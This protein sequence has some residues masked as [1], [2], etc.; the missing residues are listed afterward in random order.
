MQIPKLI[1]F[2]AQPPTALK[3][4]L[5]AIPFLIIILLYSHLGEIHRELKPDSLLMPSFTEVGDK[6]AELT[7]E[8]ENKRRPT[9]T[10]FGDTI[11]SVS[12]LLIG[13]VISSIVALV[14]GLHMGLSRG[15]NGLIGPLFTLISFIPPILAVPIVIASMG[16][17]DGGKITLI[18]LGLSLL[19][20]G[21][22]RDYVKDLPKELL[23]K[24]QTLNASWMG[25]LY[26]T[27]LPLMMP[28]LIDQLKLNIGTAWIMLFTAEFVAAS[29]GLGYRIYISRRWLDMSVIVPYMLWIAAI[30]FVILWTLNQTKKHCFRWSTLG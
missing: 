22:L 15:L 19:M 16:K 18:V 6:V 27:Y 2:H 13:M 12:N 24:T 17:D 1:G 30:S 8:P 23:I 14:L 28:K 4:L 21:N 10:L 25:V 7:T 3:V 26:R 20:A 9:P 5:G 11:S 29:Q